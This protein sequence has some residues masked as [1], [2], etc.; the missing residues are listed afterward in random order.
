M[1]VGKIDTLNSL[2]I[3]VSMIL[4]V[5]L[6]F[7][8]FLYSYAIL[9]PLHY[10][11]EVNWLNDKKFFVYQPVVFKRVVLV[12]S[13]VYVLP[14]LVQLPLLFNFFNP[15]QVA[16]FHSIQPWMNGVTMAILGLSI[17][18]VFFKELR[19]GLILAFIMGASVALL[20]KN[21]FYNSWVG[22]FLPTLIH[23][24]VFTTL[25]MLYGTLKVK[26]TAGYFNVALMVLVPFLIGALPEEYISKPDHFL[27]VVYFENNF[28]VMNARVAELFDFELPRLNM[29]IQVF[30]AF[31]YIYHY[32]NWFTK[33]T[34]IGWHKKIT[35]K[36]TIL[37]S[38]LWITSIFFY[39]IDFKTG[40]ILVLFFSVLHVFSELPLNVISIKGIGEQLFGKV[41]D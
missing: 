27:S 20:V 15:E 35:A 13:I 5:V 19:L 22:V 26:S 17:G 6:P 8:T 23:V 39:W 14:F 2:L 36:K 24:Y 9:G 30:I 18:L 21:H 25:F 3:V 33:T 10:L 12:F 7:Q 29:R 16:L 34:V 40:F 28:H 38:S 1:K 31:A 32:L 11:T 41:K 4:A 37:I